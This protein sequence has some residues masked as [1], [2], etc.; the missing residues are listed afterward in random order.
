MAAEAAAGAGARAR[1]RAPAAATLN[2]E[3]LRTITEAPRPPL[4]RDRE[5]LAEDLNVAM[6]DIATL[7]EHIKQV[8]RRRSKAVEG[9]VELAADEPLLDGEFL[10]STEDRMSHA[11]RYFPSLAAADVARGVAALL[12]VTERLGSSLGFLRGTNGFLRVPIALPADA[13]GPLARLLKE[14]SK[15]LETES[16]QAIAVVGGRSGDALLSASRPNDACDWGLAMM[17]GVVRV[18]ARGRGFGDGD[19]V[20]IRPGRALVLT[21]VELIAATGA[22]QMV[23]VLFHDGAGEVPNLDRIQIACAAADKAASTA[24]VNLEAAASYEAPPP[25]RAPPAAQAGGGARGEKVAAD[26]APLDGGGAAAR[27]LGIYESKPAPEARHRRRP[28]LHGTVRIPPPR[29][30]TAA[31]TAGGRCRSHACAARSARRWPWRG[32][33]RR[34]ERSQIR[35]GSARATRCSSSAS[36]RSSIGACAPSRISTASCFRPPTPATPAAGARRRCRKLSPA[37][38]TRAG[39]RRL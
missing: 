13:A 16:C 17:L 30:S 15:C 35:R 29:T 24:A 10:A 8:A 19:L 36:R 4:P 34:S 12:Y 37:S 2:A 5:E 23:G 31:G 21:D 32:S 27:V 25:R 33:G 14:L 6:S 22:G 28:L 11:E 1:R 38:P 39:A 3:E 20:A 9:G 18:A 26:Q 7:D